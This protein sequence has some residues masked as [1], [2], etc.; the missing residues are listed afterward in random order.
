MI[1]RLPVAVSLGEITSSV[2][3]SYHC[4]TRNYHCLGSISLLTR[5]CGKIFQD[6]I[7]GDTV[8]VYNEIHM[9]DDPVDHSP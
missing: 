1:K 9:V 7:Q 3:M 6:R 5:V 4:F 2:T 8:H